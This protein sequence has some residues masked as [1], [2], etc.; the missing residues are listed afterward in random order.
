VGARIAG[1]ERSLGAHDEALTVERAAIAGYA[2]TGN[3]R[4]WA[5]STYYSGWIHFLAGRLAEAEALTR[6]AIAVCDGSSAV[7]PVKAE[8]LGNL[9]Q[10]LLR[11]GRVEE[12][13]TT[14]EAAMAIVSSLGGTGGG[15]A[16]IRLA[17][18]EALWAAGARSEARAAISSARQWLL[19]SAERMADPEMRADFLANVGAN[20]RILER[21]REW[22]SA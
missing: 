9:A 17:H 8:A 22:R 5:V 15:E 20:A 1:E 10:V 11:A 6:E 16:G 4:L 3:K 13:V 14:G 7:L 19:A 18:A 12:A 21:A 2:A